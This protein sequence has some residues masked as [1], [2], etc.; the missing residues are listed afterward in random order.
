MVDPIRGG[1]RSKPG[2]TDDTQFPSGET[3]DEV[4]V[5]DDKAAPDPLI[6]H[7]IAD[8]L[9][10]TAVLG[11]GACGRV[12]RAKHLLLDKTVAIKVLHKHTS[13]DPR[14]AL[15]FKVEARAASR[16]DHPNSLSILDFGEDQ[17]LLYIAM[18]FLDG[19]NLDRLLDRDAP[20]DSQR[21]ARIMV[22]IC[23]ALTVAHR[24]GIV[25]RDLKPGN[26]MLVSRKTEDGEVREIVK[27]CDFGLAKSI[28]E[29]LEDVS[30]A[31]LTLKNAVVGT[32]SYMSPEQ[33]TGGTIDART[34]IYSCGVLM[35]EMLTGI[36][37][38]YG[39]SHTNIL[40][41][42][43]L[44]EPPQI[45]DIAPGVNPELAAIAHRAMQKRRE[46]RFENARDML[47]A[48]RGVLGAAELDRIQ[49]RVPSFSRPPEYV[50][51]SD[52]EGFEETADPSEP[53][54]A[55]ISERVSARL[56]QT[57]S[58]VSPPIVT[59]TQVD[60]KPRGISAAVISSVALLVSGLVVASM[61]SGRPHPEEPYVSPEPA[62]DPV[63]PVVERVIEPIEP[64]REESPVQSMIDRPVR[65]AQ[66]SARVV[67]PERSE[68]ARSSTISE[69]VTPAE[70]ASPV[71]PVTAPLES[72]TSEPVEIANAEPAPQS[73]RPR[74]V[75]ALEE[76]EVG[77]GLTR[78][79]CATYLD[80]PLRVFESCV[81]ALVG[82]D[83]FE[84]GR[85]LDVR[86]RIDDSGRL[87]NV[88]VSGAGGAVV[89]CV[90]S[91][92]ERARMPHPD[93][94]EAQIAFRIRAE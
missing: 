44:T 68:L 37:P 9:E 40:M 7:I 51:P 32:P 87:R 8:R 88:A 53:S 29:P 52:E 16:L 1:R 2:L 36:L 39:D 49:V 80:K 73:T 91:G 31:P 62:P 41:Q 22:Q 4:T 78:R 14:I 67:A 63:P 85:V 18:E 65:R 75:L 34:D 71:V 27:V 59:E 86:G 82:T 20:L 10:L 56:P 83:T 74:I 28:L 64:L 6:G 94:G 54:F 11:E 42:Q 47:I 12:Y 35:F 60:P 77:G 45:L 92:F 72:P 5:V 46:D 76:I 15:R 23:A 38:F 61:I 30:G 17:G 48:L 89:K 69:S 79:R 26:I 70:V 43:I 84:R 66:R 81:G 21:A 24:E 57:T 13:K 93:T 58:E 50:E 55:E 33:A 90:E 3:G 25:H 19:E